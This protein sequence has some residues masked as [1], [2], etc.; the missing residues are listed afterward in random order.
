MPRIDVR[1]HQVDQ[2]IIA[3]EEQ[4]RE[5]LE[6]AEISTAIRAREFRTAQEWDAYAETLLYEIRTIEGQ[7]SNPSIRV[8]DYWRWRRKA[9]T[10]WQLKN[11]QYKQARQM[12]KE[13]RQAERVHRV[14]LEIGT[15][16]DLLHQL[17]GLVKS[18]VGNGTI[19]LR[20]NE[21]RLL[22]KIQEYFDTRFDRPSRPAGRTPGTGGYAISAKLGTEERLGRLGPEYDPI[23]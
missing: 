8:D 4:E 14:R 15:P 23:E 20:P 13:L 7:L 19:A 16:E 22:A 6:E 5:A 12:A 3:R 9:R 11:A 17:N 21:E 10:A 18:W 1:D 2:R